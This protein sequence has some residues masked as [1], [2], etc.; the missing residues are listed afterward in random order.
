[1][2]RYED[3]IVPKKTV[4]TAVEKCKE[5]GM[6]GHLPGFRRLPKLTTE[7]LASVE[8]AK[9]RNDDKTT[10]VHLVCK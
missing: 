10:A 5:H 4:W 6:I 8:A 2:F 9:M 7:A 1:V 3:N